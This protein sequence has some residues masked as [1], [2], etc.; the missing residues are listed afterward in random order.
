M[1]SWDKFDEMRLP[2]KGAF[3]SN[4]NMS[5]ISNQDY[6]HGQDVWK[7]FG[8]KNLGECHDLYLK[9]DVIL[10]SHISEVF[11]STCLKHYSLNPDRF[12][13]VKP[14]KEEPRKLKTNRLLLKILYPLVKNQCQGVFK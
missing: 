14:R 10:L 7:G 8:R 12:C 1:S 3:Y 5:D 6:S 9:T 4:L 11:R 13:T 2:P